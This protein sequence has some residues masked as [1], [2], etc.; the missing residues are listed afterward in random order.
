VLSAGLRQGKE[1]V[2]LVPRLGKELWALCTRLPLTPEEQQR[3]EAGVKLELAALKKPGPAEKEPKKKSP[4][5][6]SPSMPEPFS[7]RDMA[8]ASR[9]IAQKEK[10]ATGGQHTGEELRSQGRLRF[11]PGFN[12]VWV[13]DSY[14]DLRKRDQARCCIQCLVERGAFTKKTALHLKDEIAPYVR[15]QTMDPSKESNVRIADYFNDS[16]K[17]FRKLRKL[18]ASAGWST[19]RYFLK[20]R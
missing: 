14:Y 4:S 20:V 12:D 18:I 2:V 9:T 11:G 7:D 8:Q 1:V 10:S 3:V 6:G 5:I 13:D 17:R 15:Q 16:Q 19:G